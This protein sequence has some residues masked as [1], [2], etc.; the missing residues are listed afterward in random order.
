M[1]VIALRHPRVYCGLQDRY[2]WPRYVKRCSCRKTLSEASKHDDHPLRCMPEEEP[3]AASNPGTSVRANAGTL[4]TI[5]T[6]E[7]IVEA[8]LGTFDRLREQATCLRKAAEM[9]SAKVGVGELRRWRST[10]QALPTA[11]EGT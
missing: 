9:K 1:Y 5:G 6:L 7:A 10:E 3:E 2:D 11:C 8:P 4:A